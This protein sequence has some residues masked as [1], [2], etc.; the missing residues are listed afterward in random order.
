[1]AKSKVQ[2]STSPIQNPT[3]YGNIRNM[4]NDTDVT[5]MRSHGL[6]LSDYTTVKNHAGSIYQ[7]VA[8]GNMPPGA[9]W[10]S[11]MVQTFLNWMNNDYPK[12]APDANLLKLA[13]NAVSQAPRIRKEI[14]SLLP[15]E[16]DTLKK[17]FLGIMAK[18][19]SDPNSYFAQAGYHWLPA[20]NT[21]CQHH[22][23]GYNPWHRIYLLGFEDALRSVPGCE[24]VTLPYWD[25]TTQVLP[26]VLTKAPFDSYTF[27][28]D[29]GP[30]PY[31][32]GYKTM[33]SDAATLK[34]NLQHYQ[35][36]QDINNASA[37]PDWEDFNGFWGGATYDTIISAHD[38]G[39]NSFGAMYNNPTDKKPYTMPDQDVAAFDPVFWFFHA[40]WDRLWWDW[41]QKVGAT[42]QSGLL[43]TIDKEKD[44]ISYTLF[45]DAA[46]D[47]LSPFKFSAIDSIN[48]NSLGVDYADSAF[49]SQSANFVAK[50]RKA[51]PASSQFMVKSNMV[52][53]RVQGVNR[54]KIPGSFK[55]HLTKNGKPIATRA[56]F[57]P[58]EVGKCA[59][60][61]KNAIVHFDFKLPLKTVSDGKFGVW[62][63]PINK[64]FIG[65][66]FPHKMMGNPTVE[67]HF[68]MSTE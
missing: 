57:Q 66:R 56:F 11:D 32:A 19:P 67:V 7:Q 39:H 6:D 29:V 36:T 49:S 27:P 28:K 45:T 30:A 43:S 18:D 62:V 65:D 48:L 46:A 31:T 25:I 33:R 63:E 2:T 34:A 47:P 35:V 42:T 60:C 58:S 1:M 52:N 9:P 50:T 3:W 37:Q 40:N 13:A 17:A 5:H 4:F 38:H 64:N 59:T 61:V 14:S 55:V 54:L 26:D 12:G 21:Y 15:A 20:G 8:V 22:V 44:P 10:S 68:L 16:I 24:N 41:Q 51:V 53:V 23:P